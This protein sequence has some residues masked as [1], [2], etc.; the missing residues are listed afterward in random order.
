MNRFL[1]TSLL[2]FALS[3]VP[4]HAEFLQMD[5]SIFCMD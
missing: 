2:A 5:L 4:V 3:A 1:I